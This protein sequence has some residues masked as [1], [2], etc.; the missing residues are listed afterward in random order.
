MGQLRETAAPSC[1]FLFFLLLFLVAPCHGQPQDVAWGALSPDDR[2]G[3]LYAAYPMEGV[4]ERGKDPRDLPVRHVSGL[5]RFHQPQAYRRDVASG[6]GSVPSQWVPDFEPWRN[7]MDLPV[8]RISRLRSFHQPQAYP[9]AVAPR[10]PSSRSQMDLGFEPEE[11]P[12]GAGGVRPAGSVDQKR[13]ENHLAVGVLAILLSLVILAALGYLAK[14]LLIKR[15]AGAMLGETGGDM[16]NKDPAPLKKPQNLRRITIEI[17]DLTGKSNPNLKGLPS[18]KVNISQSPQQSSR[19][20]FRRQSEIA[21]D[22]CPDT[23]KKTPTSGKVASTCCCGR[24]VEL[25]EPQNP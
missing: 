23:S 18:S 5:R 24:V 9:R 11:Y 4:L 2:V 7:R 3:D 8:R 1:C 22:S 14:Q 15:E 6:A 21:D 12:R 13:G 10:I 19:P 25:C 17:Q 16:K 20:D